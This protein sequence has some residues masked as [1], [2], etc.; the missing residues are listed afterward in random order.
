MVFK[1]GHS[2]P[3]EWV[4]KIAEK[5]R[6]RWAIPKFK[7]M[8]CKEMKK[9]YSS[10]RAEG[11][12]LGGRLPGTVLSYEVR[13]AWRQLH[14][15]Q[16]IGMYG[17]HHNLVSKEKIGQS[18]SIRMKEWYTIPGNLEL[19][20]KRKIEWWNNLDAEQQN[21]IILKRFSGSSRRPNKPEQF[22]QDFLDTY[23]PNEWLYTGN[24]KHTFVIGNKC[25]D[26]THTSK[27][28]VIELFGEYWHRDSDP[29][30]WINHYKEYDYDCLVIWTN[31]LKDIE[32]LK[33]KFYDYL[34]LVAGWS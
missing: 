9:S 29:E 23:F 6:E 3:Q 20:S 27:K 21:L 16:K 28:L 24:G 34:C 18:N 25:P 19:A 33:K 4:Y 10:R 32:T 15:E 30:D 22:L 7:S 5:A 17:R 1:K 8:V 14:R 13:E 31:E 12:F 11:K 2:V 26:Y